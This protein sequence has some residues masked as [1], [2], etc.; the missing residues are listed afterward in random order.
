MREITPNIFLI[1]IG[2]LA[3]VGA[4]LNWR[5]VSHSGKILNRLIGDLTAR[6]IYA[7]IGVI[8]IVLGAIQ[9]IEI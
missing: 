8:L 6:A 3:V 2:M 7:A 4:A 1:I 9:M 5:I